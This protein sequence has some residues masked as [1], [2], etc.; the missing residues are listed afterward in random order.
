[1]KKKKIINIFFS[2]F[3]KAIFSIILSIEQGLFLF[4]LEILDL[5]FFLLF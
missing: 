3:Y 5:I 2:A 4:I 1:M